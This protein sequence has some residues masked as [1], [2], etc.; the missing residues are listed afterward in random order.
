MSLTKVY[1]ENFLALDRMELNPVAGT[2]ILLGRNGTGKTQILKAIYAITDS[3]EGP[4]LR[5]L[6]ECF[7]YGLEK[8][9]LLTEEKHGEIVIDI[10]DDEVPT[11]TTTDVIVGKHDAGDDPDSKEMLVKIS[12]FIGAKRSVYIP[13]KDMLTHANGLQS[14]SEKYRDFPF[15]R[16]LT[17]IIRKAQQWKLKEIPELAL[18]ILPH[19]EKIMDGKIVIE[20]DEFYVKK[21]DGRFINFA[22]EAEGFKKIG[23][24]WQLLMNESI[25]EGSILLWDEPEANLNPEYLPILVECLLELSRHGVQTFVST[26]NYLF[27]KY[28]DVR[29]KNGDAVAY[30]A[31]YKDEEDVICCEKA[32]RFDE[33]KHNAIMDAYNKLLDEVYGLQVGE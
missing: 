9:R 7:K 18:N 13:V 22:V 24:L 32:D 33:L 27:A 11:K 16:T 20:D 5:I 8:R 2:N 30:H 4:T 23:L 21:N 26:H 17:R 15:D 10:E 28:F 19:L 1:L 12:S 6:L 25:T 3:M 31:L 29:R 14:M